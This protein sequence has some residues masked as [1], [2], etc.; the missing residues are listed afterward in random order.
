MRNIIIAIFGF[1][2]GWSFGQVAVSM[3]DKRPLDAI[4]W[5]VLTFISGG[6]AVTVLLS[7]D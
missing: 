1:L 5:F 7:E 2:A 6:V 3:L 4:L